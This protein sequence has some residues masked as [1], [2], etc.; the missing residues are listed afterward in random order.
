M[1][2]APLPRRAPSHCCRPGSPSRGRAPARLETH[3]RWQQ[4]SARARSLLCYRRSVMRALCYIALLAACGQKQTTAPCPEPTATAAK[5]TASASPVSA[6]DTP[7][8]AKDIAAAKTA[9]VAKHGEANKA[10]IEKGIDQVASL[11][12][13][14]D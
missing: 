4:L 3:R 11:W 8:A 2:L 13:Q 7:I 5:P 14:A 12:R 1:H 6:E 9:C 10:A